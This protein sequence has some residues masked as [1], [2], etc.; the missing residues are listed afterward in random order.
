[1]TMKFM[2][3]PNRTESKR[4]CVCGVEKGQMDV[5]T[6]PA[7][8]HVALTAMGLICTLGVVIIVGIDN[9]STWLLVVAELFLS[10]PLLIA[11]IQRHKAGHSW[12]CSV[13]YA[14]LTVTFL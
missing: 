9:P 10:A 1:M 8:R 12:R 4:K 2:N 11:S 13:R 5:R 3:D 6:L 14:S 7:Q